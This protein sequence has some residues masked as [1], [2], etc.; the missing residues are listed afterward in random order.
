[1]KNILLLG[2]GRSS[3]YL[4]KYLISLEKDNNFKF[5]I[6]D[7]SETFPFSSQI[8]LGS[9]KYIRAD[10]TD[11][12]VVRALVQ[13]SDLTISL[14]PPHMHLS[15]AMHCLELRK[16]FVTASYLT[17]EM[18]ALH[19]EAK[20]K[21]LIFMMEAGLDPGLD[22]LS[23][24]REIDQIHNQGGVIHSFT[25]YTGGLVAPESDNNPWHYK[26][27]WNPR[28]VV[29]AGQD[30]AKYLEDGMEKLIPYHRL[31][32]NPVDLDVFGQADYEGYPNRDSIK[33]KSVYKLNHATTLIRG[34]IRKKGFCSAW[35]HLVYLG[36]TDDANTIKNIKGMSLRNFTKHFLPYPLP[37][38]SLERL[39]GRS[40][41][42]DLES[43]EYTQLAYLGLLSDEIISMES[44]TPAQVLQQILME[45]L[46]LNYTDRDM[47]VMQHRFEYSLGDT[48]HQRDINMNVIGESATFTAMAKTVGL[49]VGIIAQMILENK[50]HDHGIQI[51]V[52]KN[53]YDPVLDL[54]EEHGIKF[55]TEDKIIY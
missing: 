55:A 8:S 45:R 38:E 1:M 25:S 30:G 36:L 2:S 23:A 28:N 50:I 14:L 41:S 49:P 53:L 20:E 17:P 3:I 21:Q 6:S 7:F 54:L 39:M 11:Q 40:L 9:T 48:R 22:H 16:H 4:I 19:N 27:S 12:A 46:S 31:F 43:E 26:V 42:I 24:I 34:T 44:A 29:L 5:T 15:V 10:L 35:Q 47:V 32:A 18:E 52:K 51:P 37:G 13:A 33:Y